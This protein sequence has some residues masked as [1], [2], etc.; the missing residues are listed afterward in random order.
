MVFGFHYFQLILIKE[1]NKSYYEKY[2]IRTQ[3]QMVSIHLIKTSRSINL[4]Y[5]NG[6]VS[7]SIQ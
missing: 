7:I 1:R 6:F 4:E 2:M 5:C 3:G